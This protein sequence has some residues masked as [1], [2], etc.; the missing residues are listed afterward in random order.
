[1]AASRKAFINLSVRNL[2]ETIRFWT[3]LGFEFD[4]R[5]TDDH[6]TCMVLSDDAFVM[7]LDEPRFRDFVKKDIADAS[8]HTEVIV[9]LSAESRDE[10]DQLVRAALVAGGTTAND[11][12][13]YGFMY[14][15]SF[16]DLDMHQWE[17]I[18]MD[19]AAVE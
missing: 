7:L 6:A 18:W 8:T 13:D 3:A 19:P 2:P 14:G 5:F 9:A 11:P 17:V 1:M 4:H 16:Q 12:M 15:W 10:V